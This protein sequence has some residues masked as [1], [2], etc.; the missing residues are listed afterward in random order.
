MQD[1]DADGYPAGADNCPL[2][3]NPD[4]SDYDKDGIGDSCDADPDGDGA[5][6]ETVTVSFAAA[7]GA[8][9]KLAYSGSVT[10]SVSGYGKA[11]GSCLNDA[12]YLFEGCGGVSFSGSG[13]YSLLISNAHPYSQVGMLPYNPTHQYSFNY[14]L[15]VGAKQ[16]NFRVSDGDSGYNDNSGFFTVVIQIL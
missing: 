16:A 15:G 13:Y 6:G 2:K 1:P 3:Y 12:F 11:G 14:D 4:Q 7:G 9:T 10:I 5:T 8:Y